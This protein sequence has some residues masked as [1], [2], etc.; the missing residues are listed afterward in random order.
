MANL[1]EKTKVARPVPP[2]EAKK[3]AAAFMVPKEENLNLV[4]DEVIVGREDTQVL[5][6]NKAFSEAI[7]F[8][9]PK[10]FERSLD[11]QFPDFVNAFTQLGK[12]HTYELKEYPEMKKRFLEFIDQQ[13]ALPRDKG[14]EHLKLTLNNLKE[15][16]E[17]ER[18]EEVLGD[19]FVGTVD[20]SEAPR[21]TI[22]AVVGKRLQEMPKLEIEVPDFD[23]AEMEV[24]RSAFDN[25]IENSD[26]FW[27]YNHLNIL[28]RK[29][30]FD[31]EDRKQKFID[32]I[33]KELVKSDDVLD[34]NRRTFL[35]SVKE[36]VLNNQF[37]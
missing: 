36:K 20:S 22:K 17:N 35:L 3:D 5:S 7:A 14:V 25:A 28:S 2:V 19:T 37:E 9:V 29:R 30:L 10:F 26:I 27:A 6:P 33:D 12:A 32:L 18:F 23:E 31:F 15:N 24:S 16:V 11:P 21:G 4:K 1:F 13:L 8:A 34:I